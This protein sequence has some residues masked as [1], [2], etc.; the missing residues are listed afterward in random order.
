MKENPPSQSGIF[1]RRIIIA[2]ALCSLGASLGWPSFAATPKTAASQLSSNPEV[3]VAAPSNPACT[4]PGITILTD[5]T[6]DELDTVSAHDVQSLQIAEP[7][8]GADPDKIYFTLKVASLSTVPADTNWPIQFTVGGLPYTVRMTTV[9]PATPGAPRFEFY[10]G[11]FNA[12]LPTTT[13]ADPASS[14]SV[15]G[16]ITIVVPRTGVGNPAIGSNLT[17][18]LVRIQ[19]VLG[20]GSSLTPD[21]MP[22]SLAPSG[23]YTIIGN[24]SCSPNAGTNQPRFFNYMSPQGVGD[25]AGEPSIGS[26]W[27]KEA[28]NHNH[29]VDGSP[30]NNIPNGGTS[31]YFGGFLSAMVKV[32]WDDC[33]SPA[34]TLWQNKPLTL[35]SSPH[36]FGDPIL[37]TDHTTGRTLVSQLEGLT[38]AG[39]ATDITDNDGDTFTPSEG[40][41]LPSCI[42]HQTIG[43]GPFH[44]PLTGILYPHAIY[45][46][47]Q[48]VADATASLSLDGGVTFGPGSPMFTVADCDGLHGHI[49][50]APDGTVYVPDKGC[51]GNVPL[52]NGGV[53]S[54]VV[55]ENNGATWT[56]RTIPSATT[57]GD[58][59]PSI[60]IGADGTVYLGYQ[61]LD[62]HPRI[63]VSHDKGVTWSAPVD[64][65]ASVVNGGPVLNTTFPA[66]V[67]G[68]K[69]RAAF[70]FYGSENGG[71]D[72]D[73]PGFAGVWYL[74]VATTFNGGNT[75]VTQN[76]TPGDPIQRGGVC[77]SGTCRNL[78]D[79]FDITIDK[80]GRILVGY[81]D[82]C[83]TT[84]CINGGANDFTAKAAIA[85]QSGGRRMFS[86]FDPVEPAV[87]GAPAVTGS[88][89]AAKTIASL[90]WP[91]PDNAGS[92]I[93]G[94]N[95]YRKTGAGPA[96]NL[97]ATVPVTNYTDA[98]LDPAVQYCYRVTAVNGVGEGPYCPDVCPV[99][100]GGGPDICLK[101][102]GSLG[103]LVLDDLNPDGTDN[104]SGA[105]T[106]PDPR[107]NIRELYIAEPCF[108]PGVQKLVFKMLLAPSP[109]LTSP[110]PSSQWYI[111][112]N[113]PAGALDTANFDRWFVGMKTD[114]TGVL[115]FVY[116]KFGVPLDV[117]NPNQNANTPVVVG[118]ADSGTYN[119]A[120]GVVTIVL[121]NSKAENVTAGGSLPNINIRTYFAR[122]DAGQKSQ[123]N[124]S[125]ITGNSTYTLSGNASCCQPVPLLGV[126]SRKTHGTAGTFDIAL[127]QT[128]SPGF[129]GIECRT[130]GVPSGNHTMVFTFANPLT[131]V[132]SAMVTGG[133]GSISS[134]SINGVEYIVNLTGVSNAQRL[135]VTL[136]GIADT[137]GDS[138]SSLAST[139]GVLLGDVNASGDVDSAD[140]FLVRQQTLHTVTTSNFRE[141]INTS[142]DIDSAD[143]FIARKQTLTSLP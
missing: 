77:G 124:A 57:K 122:P 108:G 24:Q 38:P 20:S 68:D 56:I 94:Y 114:A 47:S 80:E 88:L 99:P 85:R 96:F 44:A 40:S 113:R 76:I 49:K 31:L 81:D 70:A 28:I 64:V 59:D 141:D 69:N 78:L 71:S 26:N 36:V 39:S 14:F 74:Y 106:P 86:A 125:D 52:L 75:W 50:V 84:S 133:T 137:A 37:F 129:P 62:G 10:Q 132:A 95:I 100:G 67:A 127:P 101:Q 25:S 4:L 60:G 33:S 11:A 15:D 29:H 143:V 7:F 93:T 109:T 18:F 136:T 19:V 121:S 91:T 42:D 90:S 98:T 120:T 32:T 66:V 115:S 140:V 79:F 5:A 17:L 139:M 61:S 73:Q 130:G 16:T 46:A 45:Y 53:A 89:N 118:D 3:S 6:G 112:W 35:A 12:L 65:G 128:G 2:V 126:A 63:A 92:A 13:V 131:S 34:G 43:G 138:T 21:N 117:N 119:V 116:G 51:G 8:V 55:S 72:Y 123:N 104:D 105:N 23:S 41:G 102:P 135:T 134:S 22:D 142:G 48:C 1:I 83:I 27:T 54:A 9:P 110:P 103:A 87:A 97:I 58:D 30:D 111:V 107:V 82:G